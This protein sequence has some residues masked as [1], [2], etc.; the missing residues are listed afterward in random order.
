MK[1]QFDKVHA[2]PMQYNSSLYEYRVINL[3]IKEMCAIT[4]K[5]GD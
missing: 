4:F 2:N 1:L 3:N 5:D